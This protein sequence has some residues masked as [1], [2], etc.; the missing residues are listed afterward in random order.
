MDLLDD[1]LN[2]S[3]EAAAAR[4][5]IHEARVSGDLGGDGVAVRELAEDHRLVR[6]AVDRYV[7]TESQEP[8]VSAPRTPAIGW[9]A[10]WWTSRR[11]TLRTPRTT[12]GNT[13][14]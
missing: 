11:R 13:Q 12:E 9:A 1:R 3:E 8:G 14:P 7:V 6:L 10:S 2:P 4:A 5:A